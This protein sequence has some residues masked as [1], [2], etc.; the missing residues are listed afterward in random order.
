MNSSFDKSIHVKYH[1]LKERYLQ[2]LNDTMSVRLNY[3]FENNHFIS[4]LKVLEFECSLQE[5][6]Y[7]LFFYPFNIDAWLK[8]LAVPL[9]KWS[10]QQILRPFSSLELSTAVNDGSLAYL[11][12]LRDYVLFQVKDGRKLVFHGNSMNQSFMM[13]VSQNSFKCFNKYTKENGVYIDDKFV[14][15]SIELNKHILVQFILNPFWQTDYEIGED[16]YEQLS[17]IYISRRWELV[18][19]EEDIFI[20]ARSEQLESNIVAEFVNLQL[21]QN[22]INLNNITDILFKVIR[23]PF[24]DFETRQVLWKIA[25]RLEEKVKTSKDINLVQTPVGVIEEAKNIFFNCAKPTW[26]ELHS[27]VVNKRTL[28]TETEI[29]NVCNTYLI[30]VAPGDLGYLLPLL[31]CEKPNLQ[32]ILMCFLQSQ[33][34]L[35]RDSILEKVITSQIP[36]AKGKKY[37]SLYGISYL[38]NAKNKQVDIKSSILWDESLWELNHY[39]MKYTKYD[40]FDILDKNETLTYALLNSTMNQKVSLYTKIAFLILH[41]TNAC[42][43]VNILYSLE[44]HPDIVMSILVDD[45]RYAIKECGFKVS[46]KNYIVPQIDLRRVSLSELYASFLVKLQVAT[47]TLNFKEAQQ[48]TWRDLSNVK[49]VRYQ[50]NILANHLHD[51]L[52]DASISKGTNSLKISNIKRKS[53]VKFWD[54]VV[55]NGSLP[56]MTHLS[57][58]FQLS[59]A[60]IFF[61]K[62]TVSCGEAS[63]QEDTLYI[64]LEK[65]LL[66]TLESELR[67]NFEKN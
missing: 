28:L 50:I 53:N 44:N 38:I 59:E 39:M 8:K 64:H 35:P 29:F 21:Q 49:C 61:D 33:P 43:D 67:W 37:I 42:Q 30:D 31:F 32:N 22:D 10:V 62:G 34:E 15:L 16:K 54:F 65:E 23:K 6:F 27:G 19:I 12:N 20:D 57:I 52:I 51:V 46:N 9:Q 47:H 4:Q 60:T 58:L 5:F 7:N 1:R 36:E 45:I 26:K 56:T 40:I 66:P 18:P 14:S 11:Q 48:S 25:N 13:E 3:I 2:K 55:I 24:C 63:S 17:N 41:K